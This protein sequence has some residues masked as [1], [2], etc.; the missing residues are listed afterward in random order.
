M[1]ISSLLDGDEE[2]NTEEDYEHEDLDIDVVAES[3]TKVLTGANNDDVDGAA[4][5]GSSDLVAGAES[6]QKQEHTE[7]QTPEWIRI[8]KKHRVQSSRLEALSSGQVQAR[9]SLKRGSSQEA[10]VK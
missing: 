4:P 6:S 10:V 7:V 9:I 5:S 3:A 8:L 2:E 1:L